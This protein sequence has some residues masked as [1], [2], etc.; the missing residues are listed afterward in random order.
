VN[1]GLW[2]Q[3]AALEWV[4]K[5][6]H[7]VGGDKENVSAWGESAGAGS[8]MHHLVLDGGKTDPLFKRAMLQSPAFLATWDTDTTVESFTQH[9]LSLIGCEG[10]GLNCAREVDVDILHNANN[11]TNMDAAEGTF[12]YGP[13]PDGIHIKSVPGVE[14]AKGNYW[15]G[16]ESLLVSHVADEAMI[17]VPKSITDD[18]QV[19]LFVNAS[20][21]ST[22][23]K[24]ETINEL[25][26]LYP[27]STTKKGEKLFGTAEKRINT[28]I[29]DSTF[30]CN[31]RWLARAYAG[32]TYSMQYS[33][34]PG[35]HGVDLI[36]TFFNFKIPM[37]LSYRN[38]LTSHALTG[39]P[40]TLKL[41]SNDGD[42]FSSSS[43]EAIEWPLAKVEEMVKDVNNF[44]NNGYELIE[45]S[46]QKQ[47]N[48]DFWQ[49]LQAEGTEHAR[50]RAE[51]QSGAA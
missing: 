8:L 3:R 34:K 25:G 39:N 27:A 45:D 40:N 50:R 44:K 33:G 24:V 47:R 28:I 32:K 49:N 48:C 38:Y 29:R 13:V 43:P 12:A 14:F 22:S 20:A 5:Y 42:Y 46:T 19:D 2:D 6:I 10:K 31:N 26:E 30:T 4:Q 41:K 7:L 36:P 21:P 16:L 35:L 1:A 11:I 9:F 18:D 15:K 37:W 23:F 51:R 17:F